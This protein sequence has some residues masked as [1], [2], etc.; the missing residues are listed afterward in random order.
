MNLLSNLNGGA[1]HDTLVLGG[2]HEALDFASLGLKIGSVET[3]D[4]GT[5]GSNSL[6]LG[7]KDLLA[8]TDN[9][10]EALTI[11]GADGSAVTLSTAEGGVWNEAGMQ[12]IAGQ[13]FDLYHNSSAS[14]EGTL[15]DVLIQHNLQVQ[16][17]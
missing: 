12:T 13:Q 8:L 7:Q 11:K 9:A 3:I 6:T 10:S 14:H 2:A 4:L 1:G 17:A 16:T 5:S 15:A